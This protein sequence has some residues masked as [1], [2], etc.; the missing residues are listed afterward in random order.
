MFIKKI[1][2]QEECC[3][4]NEKLVSELIE[5]ICCLPV[6]SWKENYPYVSVPSFKEIKIYDNHINIGNYIYFIT[7]DYQADKLNNKMGELSK[8]E[9]EKYVK[10]SEKFLIEFLKRSE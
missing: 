10:E 6:Y 3:Y 8:L 2:K 4:V 7:Q 9:D 5:F 1:D